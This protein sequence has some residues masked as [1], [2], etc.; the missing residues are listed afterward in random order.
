MFKNVIPTLVNG[1]TILP[2]ICAFKHLGKHMTGPSNGPL[3][4]HFGKLCLCLELMEGKRKGQKEG[5]TG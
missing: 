4:C 5:E 1:S 2:F 3:F